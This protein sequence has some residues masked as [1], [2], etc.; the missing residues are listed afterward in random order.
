MNI[1]TTLLLLVTGLLVFAIL[2]RCIKWFE[3][4]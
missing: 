4:I 1:M 3:N 2:F